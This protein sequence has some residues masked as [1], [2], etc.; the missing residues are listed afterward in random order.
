[1][2]I[3]LLATAAFAPRVPAADACSTSRI[4]SVRGGMFVLATAR[5]DTLRTGP[6]PIR[7]DVRDPSRL[8]SIHGQRFRIERVGGDVPAE[9]A[10]AGTEAV[11]VPYG[12]ACR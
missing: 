2:M 9:L 5:A 4:L 8:E 11:L 3:P 1:M 12:S 6:G 10:G 7:Y